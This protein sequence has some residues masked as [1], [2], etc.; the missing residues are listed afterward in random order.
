[1]DGVTAGRPIRV[2]LCDDVQAFRVLMRHTLGEWPGIE[3]VGE[4]ADGE[5]GIG[6]VE[7]LRPDVVLL[8][9]SMPRCDGMEAIPR[10]RESVPGTQIVALSGFSA[11]RMAAPVMERGAHAYL[12]K[13][14]DVM[15]IVDTIRS[16]ASA[17]EL[18]VTGPASPTL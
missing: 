16:A 8:D 12:E 14:T 1:M 3:I 13:G 11:D 9:L 18:C 10:M 2:L 6:L 15:I 4:A 7:Q 5:E 17:S